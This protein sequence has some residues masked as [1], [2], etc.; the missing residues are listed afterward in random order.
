MFKLNFDCGRNIAYING[1]ENNNEILYLNADKNHQK[2]K[3]IDMDEIAILIENLYRSIRGNMSFKTLEQLRDA[4]ISR[5]RP[6]NRE[7]KQHYDHAMNILENNKDSEI[8][9]KEGTLIPMFDE[10]LER[11]VF[12]ISGMSGSG[13]STYTSSLCRTYK[14]QFPTNKIILFSNKPEDPVFDVLEY[15]ERI[16]IN[17]DL[18]NDPI[19]LNELRDSLVIFDDVEYSTSKEVDKELDRIRDL[20]LQQGRSYK[21]SFAYITHQSNNY[22]AT[23]TI[24]NEC[25]SVTIFPQM[26]TR[27]SLKYLLCNYFGFEKN[28]ISKICKLPS[29]HVTIFKSPPLVLYSSGAYLV[30]DV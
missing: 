20:V 30:N 27:Y 7:L 23:R 11:Q 24:L 17:E 12:M 18:L 5:K 4:I 16:V 28:D 6:V 25:N 14:K 1:G 2:Q 21:C 10:T 22:K 3:Q 15:I 26:T 19:T 13:K 29:R 9:L 8:V